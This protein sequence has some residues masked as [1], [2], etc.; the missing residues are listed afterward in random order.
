MG[1]ASNYP[2]ARHA[3]EK[4]NGNI[5]DAVNWLLEAKVT[6]QSDERSPSTAASVA[7]TAAPAARGYY[8]NVM[9]G[10]TCLVR[11]VTEVSVPVDHAAFS[12]IPA[13]YVAK[14][15]GKM[16]SAYKQFADRIISY[17]VT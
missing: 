11:P 2:T 7:T 10:E 13:E 16:G 6:P 12:D 15:I 9:T 5:Q 1:I 8:A 4:T 3:L 14:S 17:A